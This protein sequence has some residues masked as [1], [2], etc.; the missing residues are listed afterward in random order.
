MRR[1][2]LPG[3]TSELTLEMEALQ[4]IARGVYVC[5]ARRSV[6]HLERI[7]A[8]GPCL[9]VAN[10]VTE[11][12]P[13]TVGLTVVDAGRIP[14]FLAKES[15]FRIPVVGFLLR[16]IGQVPVHRGTRDSARALSDARQRLAEGAAVVI[17]PEGTLT[18]DPLRWPMHSYPGAA[19][20]ALGLGIP[21]I[22]VAHWGDEQILGRDE[23]WK[24]RVS[25]W[26][27]K[28]VRVR[29]GEPVDLSRFRSA[30]PPAPAAAGDHADPAPLTDAERV[31]AVPPASAAAAADAILD[32]IAAQLSVLRDEPVP[33]TRWDNR[34][35][36]R[37]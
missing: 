7:P 11:I 1:T 22:P 33:P 29:V 6:E 12:D 24:V 26:P 3:R 23:H 35:R 13:V 37:R 14:R 32:A 34:I 18:R 19:R 28:R 20:L 2:R 30:E 9:I 25:L 15:L 4:R 21:V 17:Y 8:E 27:R 10:H 31:A 5:A 36:G 16:R